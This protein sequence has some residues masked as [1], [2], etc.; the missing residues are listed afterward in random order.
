MG[1]FLQVPQQTKNVPES[2]DHHDSP[3]LTPVEAL[4]EMMVHRLFGVGLILQSAAGIAGGPAG[5]RLT[6]AV[7][8]MD[9]IIRD[10]R[11]AVYGARVSRQPGHDGDGGVMPD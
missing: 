2:A 8:E 3:A 10:V 7:E 4:A 6:R 11:S 1:D 5:E 9:A